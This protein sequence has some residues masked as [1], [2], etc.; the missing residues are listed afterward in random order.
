MIH[1]TDIYRQEHTTDWYETYDEEPSMS[2]LIEKVEPEATETT[3]AQ[4]TCETNVEHFFFGGRITCSNPIGD[5]DAIR[6]QILD[7]L[8][9]FITEE[10]QQLK[11]NMEAVDGEDDTTPTA[12][13]QEEVT[14]GKSTN[15]DH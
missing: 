9:Q 14:D 10:R 4:F 11:S 3:M 12:D 13:Q 6:W 7:H 5:D 15:R 8:E 2:R 1:L